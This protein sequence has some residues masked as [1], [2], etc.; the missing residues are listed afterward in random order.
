MSSYIL[1]RKQLEVQV[2]ARSRHARG[3]IGR[4]AP[5]NNHY[6]VSRVVRFQRHNGTIRGIN[7]SANGYWNP[8]RE[9]RAQRQRSGSGG[10]ERGTAVGEEFRPRIRGVSAI[11]PDYLHRKAM[12][13]SKHNI[14]SR[15]GSARL[16]EPI[17][18]PGRLAS[19]SI[20]RFPLRFSRPLAR[21]P[22]VINA[23]THSPWRR[24]SFFFLYTAR[25]RYTNRKKYA[26]V[27]YRFSQLIFGD[28]V[29][30]VSINRVK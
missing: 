22:G 16:C 10:A 19:A 5:N 15:L 1:H 17:A 26:S 25:C 4:K 29:S 9:K 13:T 24:T 8:A 3:N 18:R 7:I 11:I 2:Y 30:S 20:S 27:N 28:K 6:S 23:S 12:R 14:R 21:T